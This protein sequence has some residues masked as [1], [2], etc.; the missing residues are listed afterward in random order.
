M[1][2]AAGLIALLDKMED[3]VIA[4]MTGLSPEIKQQLWERHVKRTAWIEAILEKSSEKIAAQ[5]EGV[6]HA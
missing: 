4:V 6:S 2:T 3:V 1:V 5:I